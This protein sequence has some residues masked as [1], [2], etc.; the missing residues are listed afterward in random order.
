MPVTRSAGSMLATAVC[1]ALLLT[2]C[3]DASSVEPASPAPKATDGS[4]VG[5]SGP[6]PHKPVARLIPG[7]GPHFR[8]RIPGGT[9]Q[10]L[11]VSGGTADTNVAEAVLYESDTARSWR[12]VA[13]PWPAH[14]GM[15]GWTDDH[16]AGDL[17]TPIG[18]FGLGDAGGLSPDPGTR[19][20]YDQDEEFVALGTGFLGEPLEGSFDYVVAIDYNRVPGTS[21]LDKE[22]PL[23]PE[24]G[25]GLWIHVDHEGPTQGCVSL[26]R[27]RM[28]ELLRLLDPDKQP[29]VVMGPAQEL[30]R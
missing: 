11:V 21:P 17:R 23:G 15:R 20:P 1:A 2:G 5:Q 27:E 9:R 28:R 18:V 29:V 3:T 7:L 25:S 30:R 6:G 14:N 26:S 4:T 12:P 22:R 8:S 13:G 19:L 24:K 10:A 16:H